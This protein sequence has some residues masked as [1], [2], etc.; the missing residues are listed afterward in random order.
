MVAGRTLLHPEDDDVTTAVD[1]TAALVHAS[2]LAGSR[3]TPIP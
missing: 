1:T 3:P 2:H